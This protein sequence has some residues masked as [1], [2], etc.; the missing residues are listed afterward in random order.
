MRI[1]KAKYEPCGNLRNWSVSQVDRDTGIRTAVRRSREVEA[2]E[3]AKEAREA[4][5]AKRRRLTPVGFD[6]QRGESSSEAQFTFE[7]N[8]PA[9]D[10]LSLTL[11]AQPGQ[12]GGTRSRLCCYR[13]CPRV[14]S[15]G[16][17]TVDSR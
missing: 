8:L 13:S 15:S 3:E 17:R 16:I 11:V 7:D 2:R 9:W 10:D 12:S 4:K 5:E 6:A 14:C 1:E